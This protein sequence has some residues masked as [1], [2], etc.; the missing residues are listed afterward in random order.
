MA[1]GSDVQACINPYILTEPCEILSAEEELRRLALID[2]IKR[3]GKKVNVLNGELSDEEQIELI[4][5]TRRKLK[6]M[7]AM[8]LALALLDSLLNEHFDTD[9]ALQLKY[10]INHCSSY[11]LNIHQYHNAIHAVNMIRESLHLADIANMTDQQ[12][13]KLL[14]IIGLFHDV[15]NGEA[16]VAPDTETGDEVQAVVVFLNLFKEAQRRRN[17]GKPLGELA[18]LADLGEMT[19]TLP[20]PQEV[21]IDGRHQVTASGEE[22]VAAGIAGTVFRDRFADLGSLAFGT[23]YNMITLKLLKGQ[24]PLLDDFERFVALSQTPLTWLARDGDIAGSTESTNAFPLGLFCRAE[25]L[26]Q[27]G[28]FQ[29]GAG[30][31]PANYRGGFQVFIGG[32]FGT[33]ET[34]A[35]EVAHTGSPLFYPEIDRDGQPDPAAERLADYARRRLAEEDRRFEQVI[36]K[37]WDICTALYVLVEECHAGKHQ[38]I[39]TNLLA[40]PIQHLIPLL[41]GLERAPKER[42]DE[43]L[44]ADAK[45]GQTRA[46]HF[47]LEDYPLIRKDS[48]YANKTI[49]ELPPATLNRIFTPQTSQV[50]TESERKEQ[51]ELLAALQRMED[52]G[53]SLQEAL[54]EVYTHPALTEEQI[55]VLEHYHG[56]R[57]ISLTDADERVCAWGSLRAVRLSPRQIQ[58]FATTG[59]ISG[60][61][62]ASRDEAADIASELERIALDKSRGTALQPMLGAILGVADLTPQAFF[63]KMFYPGQENIITKGRH[64]GRICVIL[65][66]TATVVFE[67]GPKLPV[68]RGDLIGEMSAVTNEPASADVIATPENGPVTVALLSN[69][70]LNNAYESEALK[71]RA[72]EL[73]RSRKLEMGEPID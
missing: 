29:S 6:N 68:S 20:L 37:H 12:Q 35:R 55:K 41:K 1:T 2:R 31:G 71:V 26:R 52:P 28:P 38:N 64:H 4:D 59:L 22:V 44:Y 25:D 46:L 45:Q 18:A 58:S 3:A 60:S 53:Q 40:V 23:K 39:G 63:R 67:A 51:Q 69:I 36:T 33:T 65:S 73:V 8:Q 17:Q 11:Y 30:L 56:T 50:E 43:A 34:R 21:D 62:V 16:P 5:L 9:T 47:T 24:K 66:G 32:W 61:I 48:P 7:E 42:V 72:M 14:V 57:A 27:E 15:G 13:L 10:L 54:G 70:D 49:P 19:L